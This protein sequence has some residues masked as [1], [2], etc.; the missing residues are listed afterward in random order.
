[1]RR[2]KEANGEQFYFFPVHAFKFPG[3]ADVY[4]SCSVDLTPTTEA[5][6]SSLE[7]T[8]PCLAANLLPEVGSCR[9]EGKKGSGVD[10]E[11]N[12]S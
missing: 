2:E 5:P 3:P 7:Q 11:H 6:V 8:H 9:G 12:A 10:D 1:M 4:F